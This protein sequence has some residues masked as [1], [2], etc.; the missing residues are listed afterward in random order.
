MPLFGVYK[1]QKK[2]KKKNKKE[3]IESYSYLKPCV[4]IFG[5]TLPALSA[6]F[7]I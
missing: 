5:L 7:D 4:L 2:K 6:L 3:E 1:I